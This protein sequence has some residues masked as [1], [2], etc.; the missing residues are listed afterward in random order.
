MQKIEDAYDTYKCEGLPAGAV[1]N[2]GLDAI[3]AALYPADTVYYYFLA[4]RD[5]TF[6]WAETQEQHDQ[7]VIDADLRWEEEQG[8]DDDE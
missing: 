4:A 7:N 6:Y 5:G 1:C 3:N 2:P 8:G